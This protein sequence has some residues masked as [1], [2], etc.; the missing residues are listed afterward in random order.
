MTRDS[1]IKK[2]DRLERLRV[3]SIGDVYAT[4]EKSAEELESVFLTAEILRCFREAGLSS[5]V[6]DSGIGVSV[7]RDNS[8]RTRFS[9]SSACDMLGLYVQDLDEGKSQ[10][11]HGETVRETAVMVSFLAEAVGIRD[12]LY[13]GEGDA[14]Q[15]EFGRALD[16]AAA[17]GVLH[18]RPAL[19]NLQSDVDHPTQ[20]L[21]DFLHLARHFGG[22]RKL[23]GKKI[24]VSWAYS[25]SYGKPLSVPQGVLGLATRFGMDVSLAYP[26]G[27]D[28]LPEVLDVAGKQASASGGSLVRYDSMADAF[29]GADVVYPK[30]WAPLSALRERVDLYRKGDRPGLEKLE[31]K[32]LAQNAE[33]RDWECGEDLMATTSGGSAL[34]MHCLPAD[35]SGVSCERG[36]VAASVFDRWREK[37]YE[38]ASWKPYVIAALILS[39]R[40]DKPWKVL[41]RILDRGRPRR[42]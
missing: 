6:W 5:R 12:D 2:I 39:S 15:R 40:F 37:T 25:P 34:Y 24:A 18:S 22:F 31:K 28:L 30:S 17:S 16:A 7:F 32:A 9:F 23:A 38:Q 3:G 36:E 10:V 26:E 20:A 42:G 11:A 19:V 21:S 41:K 29:R 13:L 33:H 1:V 35:V 4:W 14:Y 27:Y 8:T